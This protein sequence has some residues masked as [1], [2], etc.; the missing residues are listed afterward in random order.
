VVNPL[1]DLNFDKPLYPEFIWQ[2]YGQFEGQVVADEIRQLH[3][4][5]IIDMDQ[6]DVNYVR[7]I[8][9]LP[10]RDAQD[11][12]DSVIRPDPM[13]P[14]GGGTPTPNAPQ[15][16]D[17]AGKGGAGKKNGGDQG[18]QKTMALVLKEIEEQ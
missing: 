14:P 5:G 11:H 10:L 2:D 1:L 16:N 8:M 3:V 4:A 18:K 7:S 6:R 17:R 13:P 15:G 9:G 12:P